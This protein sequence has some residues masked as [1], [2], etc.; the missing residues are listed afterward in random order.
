MG[1]LEITRRQ[2]PPLG[3]DS[4]H[5]SSGVPAGRQ[6]RH[7]DSAF[8]RG[9]ERG[10][11]DSWRDPRGFS[12]RFYTSEGNLDIVGNNTPDSSFARRTVERDAAAHESLTGGNDRESLV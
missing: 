12:L 8:H 10:T 6:D 4:N 3:R 2:G 7:V 5:P 9:R 11:P 1:S